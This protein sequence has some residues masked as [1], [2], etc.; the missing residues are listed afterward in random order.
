MSDLND[1]EKNKFA[2]EYWYISVDVT[3]SSQWFDDIWNKNLNDL[4][5][6]KFESDGSIR[7]VTAI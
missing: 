6:S 4:E 5:K 3:L 2:L 1:L 7:I